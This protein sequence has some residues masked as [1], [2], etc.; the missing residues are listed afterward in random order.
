M[1]GS[2][3]LAGTGTARCVLLAGLFGLGLSV[4]PGLTAQERLVRAFTDEHGLDAGP[5]WA[6]AQDSTG[7]LW[8]GTEAGLFR[9]DGDEFRRWVPEVVR[10]PV[11]SV[12]VGADGGVVAATAAGR[13]FEVAGDGATPI[14][15]PGGP[16][17]GERPGLAFDAAGSLW[18]ITAE[19]GVAYRLPE[20]RWRRLPAAALDGERPYFIAAR[21]GR[22]VLVG[23][24]GGL[25]QVEPGSPPVRRL[26][27]PLAI[28]AVARAPD[29]AL[30]LATS[31]QS[32]GWQVIEHHGAEARPISA[33][34][35]APHGRPIALVERH[36]AI[37]VVLD[38]FLL[39]LRPGAPTEV[40]GRQ[41]RI[42]SG[43]PLLLDREGSLWLGSYVGLHH[44][45]EPD[46]RLWGEPQG[47]PSQH[48][49]YLARTGEALW[50]MTWS[51]PAY[52]RRA[53]NGWTV[54]TV[55][56][57]SRSNLC[58][59]E[60]GR[61]WTASTDAVLEVRDSVTVPWPGPPPGN[62]H[63][64][65]PDLR[66]GVWIGGIGNLRHLNPA[67]GRVRMV[68]L[69]SGVQENGA[70]VAGVHDS[71]DR[72]WL[73]VP[74][75]ICHAPVVSLLEPGAGSGTTALPWS[76]D[77]VPGAEAPARMVELPDGGLWVSSRHVGVLAREAEGWRPLPMD[78]LPT[79]SVFGLVH[80]PRGGIWVLG[81]GILERVRPAGPAGWEVLERLSRRH[82]LPATS[83]QH[84][85][86]ED[87]GSLW[88]ASS[89]G[90]VQIPPHARFQAAARPSV[91]LV[92]ARVDDDPVP[93]DRTLVLPH[94]RN[95]I[96]LRFAAL[97]F[98]DRSRLKHQ[99]RLAPGGA[100]TE[101]RGEPA[102]RWVDLRPGN[103][104]F[105]YRASVD[106]QA[107]ST[108]AA[109]FVV[110]VR[111]PWY[112]TSW[113]LGLAAALLALGGWGAYRARVA[114]LV[115]LE[116]QRTRIAM[117]LHDEVGSGLASVGILSGVLAA[118]GLGTR[119]RRGAAR[120]IARV[121]ERL[122]NSLSHIV[123][124]L[125]PG[126]PA[127]KDLA[128]RLAEHGAHLFADD[129]VAFTTRFPER[130]PG[131]SLPLDVR[132]NVLLIGMEALHNAARH[133]RARHVELV[134]LPAAAG[135]WQLAVR[136]DGVGADPGGGARRGRGL[137]A[138]RARAEAI[139]GVFAVRRRTQG[140]TEVCLRFHTEPVWRRAE[141]I[142]PGPRSRLA[143]A[144]RSAR[145]LLRRGRVP[146]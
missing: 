39:A 110:R 55:T 140:G 112:A 43:G 31:T 56:W 137:G 29:R 85:V 79:R 143:R 101:V 60:A 78:G 113:F 57:D 93:I 127:L 4:P 119:E 91:A 144:T 99:V 40:L 108:L 88:I 37:W 45:P 61:V 128:A 41:E 94:N 84:L 117:D 116:R 104:R 12:A 68:P 76:C 98:R 58:T 125:D 52:L 131:Q 49:R 141:P 32:P 69:P 133:A 46:T 146:A 86:E 74:G 64:C 114:Y 73:V 120:E 103:Y 11:R 89:R 129:G 1:S 2:T 87:D 126:T 33:G 130:W 75:R 9:F 123:W 7:F 134:V 66:G 34:P 135:A 106:G 23:T 36:G 14:P 51:G 90:V 18:V 124:S 97:S 102:F 8:A 65:T 30:V 54:G 38:R 35:D 5:V 82:G 77:T 109:P 44:L 71:E 121:A 92:E 20:G 53:G 63:G 142:R 96:E 107:W 95:R 62:V 42:E 72:L 59:D 16:V 21:P 25:W 6:L 118:D 15:P 48:T 80:S 28:A 67:S 47:I 70:V 115:G 83:G 24:W 3:A 27:V 139:G 138:M 50:V 17:H 100:W 132:R 122:G 13:L 19:D 111:P 105:E 81:H 22:G 136:D 10:D 26:A 145:A